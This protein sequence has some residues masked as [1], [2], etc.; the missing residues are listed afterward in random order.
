MYTV[1]LTKPGLTIHSHP[2]LKDPFDYSLTVNR[3]VFP[4][5]Y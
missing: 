2:N 3:V 5:P 4:N 1:A